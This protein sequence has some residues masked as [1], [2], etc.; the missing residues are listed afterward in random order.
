MGR[1]RM[2]VGRCVRVCVRGGL[3]ICPLIGLFKWWGRGTLHTPAV[4]GER[5]ETKGEMARGGA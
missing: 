4:W 2:G 5:E 1:E 3:L